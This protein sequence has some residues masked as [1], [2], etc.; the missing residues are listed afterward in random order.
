VGCRCMTARCRDR[1]DHRRRK[2]TWRRSSGAMKSGVLRGRSGGLRC[3]LITSGCIVL[4]YG[5]VRFERHSSVGHVGCF[6]IEFEECD[7][8]RISIARTH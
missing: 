4:G 5:Y 8:S 6:T 7:F 3:R 2:I 1:V